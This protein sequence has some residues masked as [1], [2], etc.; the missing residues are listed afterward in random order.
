[1]AEHHAGELRRESAELQAERIMAEELERQGRTEA[2][3]GQRRQSDP[4]KWRWERG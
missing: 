2:E 3:L 1:V 4:V